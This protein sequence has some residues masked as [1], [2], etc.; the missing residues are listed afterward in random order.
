MA[1]RLKPRLQ[2]LAGLVPPGS[3]VADIG[4]DH[5]LLPVY[6]VRQGLAGR[7]IAVENRPTTLEQARRS[8]ERHQCGGRI[9]LRGGDGLDPIRRDDRVDTVVI[10]GLGGRTICRILQAGRDKWDWFQ[11]FILQPMQEAPLLRRWL[12]A[13]GFA[14]AAEKLRRADITFCQLECNLT[15]RGSRVPQARHTHR[16]TAAAAVAMKDAGFSVVSF[17]GNHCMDWGKEGFFDTIDALKG[18]DLGVVG[19]GANITEARAPLII[20]KDGLK[21]AFLAYS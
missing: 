10:A 4:T 14:L 6:L 1:I 11:N 17:A 12:F 19:V 13:H 16:S 18:A 2:A 8:L 3:I 21:V 7:A 20:E 9:D 15:E 5:A